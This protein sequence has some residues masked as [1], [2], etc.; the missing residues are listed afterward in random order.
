LQ[1]HKGKEYNG[2]VAHG[3]HNGT[4]KAPPGSAKLYPIVDTGELASPIEEEFAYLVASGKSLTQAARI[5]NPDIAAPHNYGARLG[6]EPRIIKRIDELRRE[7][8]SVSAKT[9]IRE[10]ERRLDAL[11][12]RWFRFNRIVDQRAKDYAANFPDV[13]GGDT[14][15]LAYKYVQIGK[16]DYVKLHF[17][18]ASLAD[19]IIHIERVAHE[20]DKRGNVLKSL[21][22]HAHRHESREA[23]SLESKVSKLKPNQKQALL[24]AF[25][26]VGEALT[27]EAE[28]EPI[29]EPSG[30]DPSQF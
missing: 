4:L 18:D 3:S 27:I 16:D 1:S 11:E 13:P 23:D 8:T 10:V 9:G 14:G 17:F 21:H 7:V 12:A 30:D 20:W 24:E 29:P 15:F 28:S 26:E 19:R 22:L 25:P 5:A 6:K 2:Y